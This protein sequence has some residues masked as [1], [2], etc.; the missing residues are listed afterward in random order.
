MTKASPIPSARGH[1]WPAVTRAL[2]LASVV[3]HTPR[4]CYAYLSSYPTVAPG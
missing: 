1:R 2:L 4:I 3:V